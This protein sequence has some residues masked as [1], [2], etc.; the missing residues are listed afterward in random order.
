MDLW[1]KITN[2]VTV[3]N[4]GAFVFLLSTII[5]GYY[6]IRRLIAQQH[7]AFVAYVATLTAEQ[8]AHIE[9]C[10]HKIPSHPEA[11]ASIES[12]DSPKVI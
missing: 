5:L 12:G 9:A 7:A 8:T 2:T 10:I 1:L 6:K 11:D 3:G 4:I